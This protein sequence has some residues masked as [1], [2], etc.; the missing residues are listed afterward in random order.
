MNEYKQM[1]VNVYDALCTSLTAYE[2]ADN[3]DDYD[4]GCELYKDIV[5]IEERLAEFMN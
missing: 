4:K 2:S 3:S 1:L 5:E